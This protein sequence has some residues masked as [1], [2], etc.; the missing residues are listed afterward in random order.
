MKKKSIGKS[1]KEDVSNGRL[2]TQ[3]PIKVIPHENESLVGFILRVAE[4]NLYPSLLWLTAL[5]NRVKPLI[6][7]DDENIINGLIDLLG[8]TKSEIKPLYGS[9]IGRYLKAINVSSSVKICPECLKLNGYI[10]V[11][12]HVAFAS[13]CPCHG[14]KLID[15]CHECSA[16]IRWDR[17]S[18]KYCHCGADLTEAPAE[19]VD[20]VIIYYNSKIWQTV[21]RDV[22]VGAIDGVPDGKLNISPEDLNY[23]YRAMYTLSISRHPNI[24]GRNP[25]GVAEGIYAF[26]QIHPLLANWPLGF[27]KLLDGYK[28][29]K[30]EFR[31]EGL[32]QAFSNLSKTIR[33][34]PALKFITEAYL[35]Y[36]EVNWK[37]IID[38]RYS[39]Y[40]PI[41]CGYSVL[42]PL[43]KK[44]GKSRVCLNKFIDIGVLA[45]IRKKRPSGRNYTLLEIH[46]MKRFSRL[47][48]FAIN[49]TETCQ[50]M[51]IS[52]KEFDVLVRSKTINPIVRA[53]ERKLLEWWCDK[54]QI[55]SYMMEFY[56][57]A[58]KSFPKEGAVNLS[59]VC[60]AHLTDIDI[61]PE[62]LQAILAGEM[63]VAGMVEPN[64]I[65]EFKLSSMY[66]YPEDVAKFRE[67]IKNK[68]NLT[69]S[70]LNVAAMMGVKQEVAYHLVNNGFLKSDAEPGKLQR[71]RLVSAEDI[72]NFKKRYVKLV[73]LARDRDVCPRNLMLTF[74]KIGIKPAIGGSADNCRQ[75]FYRCLDL[76]RARIIDQKA[77]H[78]INR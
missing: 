3:L 25:H 78:S 18:V 19:K 12:W 50:R 46:E 45:G 67:S 29:E 73:D 39:N 31:G 51:G 48:R 72:E 42:K 59:R 36:V 77:V 28:D 9:I 17:G 58:P 52:K 14:I 56:N 64:E 2:F 70:I 40:E 57:V 35:T 74:S 5:D 10:D 15:H 63:P 26:E 76:S 47:V 60:Q 55:M 41:N 62:F 54:R 27:Y 68:S 32:N 4:A 30:G 1:R 22:N 7:C 49:K 65:E 61:F 24:A 11:L 53:G 21:G 71:G 66:F 34:R 20:D 69:F 13:A 8:L 33:N 37:G 23:L 16:T 38:K 75:V 44:T 6:W 43:A